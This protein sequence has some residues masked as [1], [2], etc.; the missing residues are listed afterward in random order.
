[1]YGV[2][3]SFSLFLFYI[4]ERFHDVDLVEFFHA[5]VLEAPVAP[6]VPIFDQFHVFPSHAALLTIYFTQHG[7]MR[8]AFISLAGLTVIVLFAILAVYLLGKKYLLLWQLAQEGEG[9]R[10]T[11]LLARNVGPSL[12]HS[13]PTVLSAMFRKE[14]VAFT[15]NSRGQ[16]W[17]GFIL[18]IW[19]MQ[20]ASNFL[21]LH[22]LGA[23]RVS[24]PFAPSVVGIL[25]FVVVLYFVAMFVLRFAFPSFSVERKTAWIIGSAPVNLSTVFVSKLFFF[26][27]L[28]AMLSALFVSLNALILGLSF[29]TSTLLVFGV[30]SASFFLTV[31]GLTIGAIFP[32]D[33]TDDPEVLTTTLPGLGFILGTIVYGALGAFCLRALLVHNTPVFFIAFILCSFVCIFALTFLARKATASLS[34]E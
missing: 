22:G 6:L 8:E 13:T 24:S 12:I 5:R 3:G 4:W 1:M 7:E 20:T 25:Q 21:L 14:V 15:R 18:L 28:F 30:M 11:S 9:V 29:E 32:N 17:L 23:E 34:L 31:L 2:I 19:A 33:E 10:K 16:L 27:V 26:G